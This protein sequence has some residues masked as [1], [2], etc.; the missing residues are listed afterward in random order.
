MKAIVVL[1]SM[2]LLL[3]CQNSHQHKVVEPSKLIENRY[4]Y[5]EPGERAFFHLDEIQVMEVNP[6]YYYSVLEWLNDELILYMEETPLENNIYAYNLFT[7][8]ITE[9]YSTNNPVLSVRANKN[10][11]L[12]ALHTAPSSYEA[13]VIVVN[14]YGIPVMEYTFPSYDLTYEWNPFNPEQLMITSF[15]EDW[16]FENYMMEVESGKV[17]KVLLSNP[18]VHWVHDQKVAFLEWNTDEPSLTAPLYAF[19]LQTNAMQLLT[20]DVISFATFSNYLFTISNNRSEDHIADYTLYLLPDMQV[21]KTYTAP[22][23]SMYSTYLIPFIEYVPSKGSLFIFQPYDGGNVDNYAN[24]YQLK[25]ISMTEEKVLFDDVENL[26]LRCA[27]SGGYCLYGYQYEKIIDINKQQI[28][29][30]METQ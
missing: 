10:H 1:L 11:D 17:Q 16:S 27:P 30:I 19:D 7:G 23:L 12:F 20:E 3:G 14:K 18:F 22:I 6:T 25:S 5:K 29:N 24:K 8:D 13:N 15:Q 26:P 2:L 21:K 28:M 4:F 9:F